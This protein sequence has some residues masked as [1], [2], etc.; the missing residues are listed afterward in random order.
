MRK[1]VTAIFVLC[2][3]ACILSFPPAMMSLAFTGAFPKKYFYI[4]S[5]WPVSAILGPV[6]AWK[7]RPRLGAWSLLWFLPCLAYALFF[8][9]GHDP[10]A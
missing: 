4:L 9:T 8:L 10:G 6:L 3:I 5:L 7:M 1:P 2:T